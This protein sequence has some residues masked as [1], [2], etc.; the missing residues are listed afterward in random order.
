[1]E[2]YDFSLFFEEKSLKIRPIKNIWE[3][4]LIEFSRRDY[5]FFLKIALK[6]NKFYFP[7][8]LVNSAENINDIMILHKDVWGIITQ[9]LENYYIENQIESHFKEQKIKICKNIKIKNNKDIA[10]S[11][12]KEEDENSFFNYVE[13]VLF[14]LSQKLIVKSKAVGK[15]MILVGDEKLLSQYKKYFDFRRKKI[16]V[17]VCIHHSNFNF[18]RF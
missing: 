17:Y 18:N 11:T 1:M 5:N 4:K 2:I 13:R 15:V 3:L 6:S 9:I 12:L 7:L 8:V 14:I 10:I 16:Q